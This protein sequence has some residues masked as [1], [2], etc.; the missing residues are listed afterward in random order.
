MFKKNNKIFTRFS[1]SVLEIIT[2]L[3]PKNHTIIGFVSS[4]K[5]YALTNPP[6]QR[7][8]M[9][10]FQKYDRGYGSFHTL[11]TFVFDKPSNK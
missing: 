11:C 5:I 1:H 3:P 7:M 8:I 10:L 9:E 4:K 6:V 2:F